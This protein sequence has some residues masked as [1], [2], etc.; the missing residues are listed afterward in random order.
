MDRQTLLVHRD[1]W[2]LESTPA[3]ARLER[4]SV[5]ELRLYD[6]LVSDRLGDRVR[7]EQERIDW[8]WAEQHFPF[9]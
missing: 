3:H 1:R 6:D 5:E 2:G 7:L 9:A 4:L 8:G